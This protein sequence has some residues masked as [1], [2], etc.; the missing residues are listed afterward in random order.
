MTGVSVNKRNGQGRSDRRYA[1]AA[2]AI[3]LFAERG[4]DETTVD[5]I[6]AAADVSSRTFFRYFT[7]KESAAFPDH[8]D[9][10]AELRRRLESR[11]PSS[12][13]FAAALDVCRQSALKFFDDPDLYRT[14][15]QLVRSV[16]ALRDFE[17]IADAAYEA[18][19]AEFIEEETPAGPLATLTAKTFAASVVSVVNYALEVW[20]SGDD[21][22]APAV[23]EVGLQS[24]GTRFS[25]LP[26]ET[27]PHA[28]VSGKGD[29]VIFVPGSDELREQ[30]LR[31]IADAGRQ[32]AD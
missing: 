15:Y 17:R 19:I 8:A 18:V 14:R 30:I 9:R 20:A 13:P 31:A 5:D 16:P 4:L 25:S 3:R 22:D 2:T 21:V 28:K 26:L 10:V 11:R 32:R 27:E 12:A 6:A 24:I 23:L 7:S 29:L 1:V